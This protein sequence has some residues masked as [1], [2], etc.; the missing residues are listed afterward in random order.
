MS[1]HPP[2]VCFKDAKKSFRD[3]ED[4]QTKSSLARETPPSIRVKPEATFLPRGRRKSLEDLLLEQQQQHRG[5]GAGHSQSTGALDPYTS[6]TTKVN[7]DITRSQLQTTSTTKK[8]KTETTTKGASISI[9]QPTN[10]TPLSFDPSPPRQARKSPLESVTDVA[11]SSSTPAPTSRTRK[12]SEPPKPWDYA[13]TKTAVAEKEGL[14]F[15]RRSYLA[16]LQAKVSHEVVDL[17][18]GERQG[19]EVVNPAS[20]STKNPFSSTRLNVGTFEVRRGDS[21]SCSLLNFREL[22]P[23]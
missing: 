6:T 1:K 17:A 11:R 13:V 12:F 23:P 10:K 21:R 7:E 15:R 20:P 14:D 5:G 3:S 8:T 9:S 19:Q 16:S 2:P 4:T 22:M 18:M